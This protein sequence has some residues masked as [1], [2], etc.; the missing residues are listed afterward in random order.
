MATGLYLLVK[1]GGE[2]YWRVDYRIFNRRKTL[3]LGVYPDVSLRQARDR[4]D[5][6]CKQVANGIDPGAIRQAK[7]LASADGVE[8]IAREWH[9]KYKSTWTAEHAERVLRRLE[10]DVFPWIGRDPIADIK[11]LA[12]LSVLRR[13]EKRGAI[14]AA[15]SARQNC[16]QVFRYAVATGRAERD[17]S[18]D[19]K[20]ALAPV[21]A[22]HFASVRGPK[23][24][25]QLLRAIDGYQGG[26]VTRCALQL[27]PLVFVRP[28]ELRRAEWAEIGPDEWRIPAEKMKMRSPHI[29]PL[30]RRRK[31]FSTNCARSPGA[32][33]MF[34]LVSVPRPAP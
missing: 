20:G 13:I 19:L 30:S 25:G 6:A 10:K 3:A 22:T 15:Y 11:A 17:P 4:R 27:A 26:F 7:K 28:G 21:R 9:S 1:P 2:R 34:S 33:A 18:A 24:I 14:Q 5:E 8:A 16:G 12:L 23:A 29:V 31:P 32:T